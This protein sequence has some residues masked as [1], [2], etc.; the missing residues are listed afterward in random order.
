MA[1]P[2][3]Q[4]VLNYESGPGPEPDGQEAASD[5]INLEESAAA[6]EAVTLDAPGQAQEAEPE[7]ESDEDVDPLHIGNLVMIVGPMRS[8]M[9]PSFNQTEENLA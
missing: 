8:R 5:V 1:L 3:D 9:L 2:E 6:P 7:A 4:I